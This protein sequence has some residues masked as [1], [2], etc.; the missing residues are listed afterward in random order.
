MAS[1]NEVEL[2]TVAQSL[3]LSKCLTQVEKY[4]SSYCYEIADTQSLKSAQQSVLIL[5]VKGTAGNY[6]AMNTESGKLL[7]NAIQNG[8]GKLILRIWKGGARWWKLNANEKTRDKRSE[9]NSIIWNDKCNV[10]VDESLCDQLAKAEVAGYRVAR[11]TLEF[12]NSTLNQKT[13]KWQVSQVCIPQIIY[14][15]DPTKGEQLTENSINKMSMP[16]AI[17][18]YVGLGSN[19]FQY[20]KASNCNDWIICDELVKNMVKVRHEFGFDEPHPR[21]GRVCVE[22]ALSYAL[23]VLYDIIVPIHTSFFS[24][25]YNLYHQQ[26]HGNGYDCDISDANKKEP[27]TNNLWIHPLLKQDGL[28]LSCHINK[29]KNGLDSELS[30]HCR[31]YKYDDMID[32]LRKA[33][34]RL[35]NESV[36]TPNVY[37]VSQD[38]EGHH[39]A[40]Q[41]NITRMSL[42]FDILMECV[43]ALVS[44][45]KQMNDECALPAVLCH[46]DLQPQNMILCRQK[47]KQNDLLSSTSCHSN[48]DEMSHIFSVLDWEE[49]CYADPRFEILL[50]CRKVVANR[51]QAD[52]LWR[53]YTKIMQERFGTNHRVIVGSIEPWLKLENVHS[54]ITLYMQC[55]DLGGRNPWERKPQVW[56]KIIRELR[57]LVDLGWEFCNRAVDS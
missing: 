18:S 12:Y 26:S 39:G 9:D 51:S 40:N 45:S 16:W 52:F 57:R 13:K 24:V 2:E 33:L 17:F 4:L 7:K 38:Q 48:N 32:V 55:M 15:H 37:N 5:N 3:N 25:H 1:I 47:P 22:Q 41:S 46:I 31:P 14:F 35:K 20:K 44:E 28:N 50:L 43:D 8:N 56:D 53:E 49:S 29:T 21:H 11:R 6:K 19:Y 54:L 30:D 36:L 10:C 27:T 23:R 42:L 34:S